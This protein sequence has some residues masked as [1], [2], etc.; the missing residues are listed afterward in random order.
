M[1]GHRYLPRSRI[2]SLRGQPTATV[3]GGK[4]ESC[5]DVDDLLGAGARPF[6]W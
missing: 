3:R 2:S 6:L 4:K 5:Q 1:L